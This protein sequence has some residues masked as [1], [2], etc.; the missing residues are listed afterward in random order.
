MEHVKFKNNSAYFYRKTKRHS[1]IDVFHKTGRIGKN[2][3]K[4][5]VRFKYLIEKNKEYIKGSKLG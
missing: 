3:G 4:K 5:I 2:S 1:V